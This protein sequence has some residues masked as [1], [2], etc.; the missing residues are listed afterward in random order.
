[1]FQQ[2]TS[3]KRFF[4]TYKSKSPV[5]KCIKQACISIWHHFYIYEY[6]CNG[7]YYFTRILKINLMKETSFISNPYICLRCLH[8]HLKQHTKHHHLLVTSIGLCSFCETV[9]D[10]FHLEDLKDLLKKK[11]HLHLLNG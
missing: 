1:M 8:S 6:R 11:K 7:T 10:V 5:F 9:K 4:K 3:I 2:T